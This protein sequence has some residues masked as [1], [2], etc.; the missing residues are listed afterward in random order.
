MEEP[1]IRPLHAG[2]AE[3]LFRF[4]Q[5]LS[6]ETAGFYEPY[7]GLT[8]EKMEAVVAQAVSGRDFAPVLVAASGEIVG[9]AFLADVSTAEPTLGIG[10]ADEWQNRGYGPRLVGEVLTEADARAEVQA[11]V[12][13]VNK[14][15]ARALRLYRKLGFIIY[16][17]CDHREPGD[18]FRMRRTRAGLA[19]DARGESSGDC[20]G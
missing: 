19:A 20:A 5:G 2:N 11:V 1:T 16:G 4:Y 18:S 3:A 9:H 17:E 12:L 7:T 14:Q 15:N 10:L 8:L 6:P 13:T